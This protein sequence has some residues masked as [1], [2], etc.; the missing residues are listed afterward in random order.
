M[1][2][3]AIRLKGTLKVRDDIRDTMQILGMKKKL[4]M[5]ILPNNPTTAGML[6]KSQDFI[7]WGELSQE[8][9]EQFKGKRVVSL[10]PP[11]GGFRSLK[12]M[13]PKGDLGY[14]GEKINEL[15]KRMI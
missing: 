12:Q 14:R 2:L 5:S 13:Y 6:R 4:S 10:K 1:M 3:A 7:A 9:G 8:L 11:K 15:I